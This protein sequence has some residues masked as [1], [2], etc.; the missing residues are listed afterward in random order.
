M[1]GVA[2]DY[3]SDAELVQALRD[4]DESAF[5]WLL[6]RYDAPL[7]RTALMY[8]PTRA[9][10]DEAVQETWLGVIKGIDRFEGRSSLKTWIFRILMNIAR[11]KGVRETRAIPFASARGAMS[12]GDEPAFDPDRFRPASDPQYPFHW[13]SFPT[14]WEHEPA[15][16]LDAA[17]TLA[18]VRAAL[19]RLPAAQREVVTLRDLEGWSSTEV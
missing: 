17:E 1:G 5:A 6:D 8:V 7:R 13:A 14:P 2:T 18:V 10:A 11:T 12:E 9:A 4:G 16:R 3:N 15:E 19:E